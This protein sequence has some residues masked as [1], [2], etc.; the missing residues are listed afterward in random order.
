MPGDRS[1][2]VGLGI[3]TLRGQTS[4]IICKVID[5]YFDNL[6][7]VRIQNSDTMQL[8]T[9]G[10]NVEFKFVIPINTDSLLF[11]FSGMEWTMA[12]I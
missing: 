6:Q 7:G 5:E 4:T 3:P 1:E 9:T 2:L 11:G 12:I 8:G 10:I